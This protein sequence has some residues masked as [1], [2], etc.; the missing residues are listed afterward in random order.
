M[1]PFDAQAT[2]PASFTRLDGTT[3]KPETMHGGGA[4]S[5]AA[6]TGW[7]AVELPYLG[8]SL[9][10]DII[11]PDDLARFEAALDASTFASI[12]GAFTG[13]EVDL[14]LPRFDFRMQAD[15]SDVLAALG[16]PTAFDPGRA[17]FSGIS[18][19]EQ[20]YVSHVIHEATITVDEKGTEAAA[21]TAVAIAAAAAPASPVTLRVD[22]PFVFALRDVE[23]GAVLF[24]GR[25]VDPTAG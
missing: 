9:A 15:L 11:L 21:A 5:Y 1:F 6:G 4:V 8:G 25:V 22:R 17:D 19:A 2:A 13:R 7:Q 12:S 23:T 24:L 20:L 16:M 18:T 3:V 14:S 10:L